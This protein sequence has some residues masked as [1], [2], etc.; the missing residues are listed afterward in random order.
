[1]PSTTQFRRVKSALRSTP[2][3]PLANRALPCQGG[4]ARRLRLQTLAPLGD[5]VVQE[6]VQRVPLRL[7]ARRKRW[8]DKGQQVR[9]E[10]AATERLPPPAPESIRA[11]L[12]LPRPVSRRRPERKTFRQSLYSD[13]HR[14]ALPSIAFALHQVL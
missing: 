14:R 11:S 1:M 6:G 13:I 5:H 4:C 2:T 9:P 12:F 8:C 10:T 7:R 3:G